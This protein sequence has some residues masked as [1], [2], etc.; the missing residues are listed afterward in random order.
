MAKGNSIIVG[1]GGIEAGTPFTLGSLPRI[2]QTTPPIVADSIAFQRTQ[3]GTEVLTVGLT[4]GTDWPLPNTFTERLQVVGGFI[5]DTGVSGGT[6]HDNVLMGRAAVAQ[7]TARARNVVIGSPGTFNDTQAFGSVNLVENVII[8]AGAAVAG[9]NTTGRNVIIGADAVFFYSAGVQSGANVFIGAGI[10]VTNFFS[11]VLIGNGIVPSA[12]AG[13]SGVAIGAIAVLSAAVSN[14][15]ALGNGSRVDASSTVALGDGA[16]ARAA[17]SIALGRNADAQTANGMVVGGAN[18]GIFDYLFGEGALA[19]GAATDQLWHFTGS[20]GTDTPGGDVVYAA[21]NGTGNANT[22]GS[23]IWRTGTPGATGVGGQ[24]QANR[25]AVRTPQG[26]FSAAVDFLNTTDAAGASTG[27]LGNAPA[28]TDPD[29]WLPL[30]IDGVA[31]AV[32]AWLI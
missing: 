15:V 10:T 29:R 24:A 30:L 23:F 17:V 31:Y 32:P 11:G 9:T 5:S 28:A 6:Q 12:A 22:K 18:L 27:T 14:I 16:R 26:S 25:L 19:G 3:G 4:L 13:S 21:P 2:T 1:G 20:Q 8:G 7:Q